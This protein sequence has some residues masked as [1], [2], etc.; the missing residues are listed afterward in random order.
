MGATSVFH[1]L[2]ARPGAGFHTLT[3]VDGKGNRTSRRFEVLSDA[4]F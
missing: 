4:D 2:E 1:D 3:L